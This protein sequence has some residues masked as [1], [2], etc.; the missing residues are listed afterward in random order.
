MEFDL[1]RLEEAAQLEA[2][3]NWIGMFKHCANWKVDE[4]S[5]FLA[6][7]GTG[8][9]LT[10]LGKDVVAIPMYQRAIELAPS[11]PTVFFGVTMSAA[12]IWYRLGNAFAKLGKSDQAIDAFLHAVDLDPDAGM[13]WNNLGIAYLEKGDRKPG[14]EAFRRAVHAAPQDTAFLKNLGIAY[15]RCNMVDG[16]QEVHQLLGALNADVAEDFLLNAQKILA[17][18]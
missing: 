5:N 7:Q 3:G 10:Q 6:W 2:D 4:P 15:A 16:V 13:T 8:D 12:P 14:I 18:F 11:R 1:Q 17:T 9:A